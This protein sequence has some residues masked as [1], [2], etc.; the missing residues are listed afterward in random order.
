MGV[1]NLTRQQAPQEVVTV[2]IVMPR[3]V[4][5]EMDREDVEVGQTVMTMIQT[6]IEGGLAV[7]VHLEVGV[8]TMEVM[9][10]TAMDL[11]GMDGAEAIV[12]EVD[13]GAGMMMTTKSPEES[14]SR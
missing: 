12:V 8:E 2:V 4:V 13:A 3:N 5:V 6:E 10:R 11:V 14:S 9:A 1:R 7:E